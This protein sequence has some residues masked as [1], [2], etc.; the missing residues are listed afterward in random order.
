[1]GLTAIKIENN[2]IVFDGSGRL[3][4]ISGLDAIKQKV[5]RRLTT[6]Q[7]EYKFDITMGLNWEDIFDTYNEELIKLAVIDCIR[8]VSEVTDIQDITTEFD[9]KNRKVT[10][11][12][13]VITNYGNTT[14]EAVL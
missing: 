7:S 2:D 10:L 12:A 13:K 14:V 6:M 4:L 3:E 9:R 5:E 8:Q 1:M 11:S